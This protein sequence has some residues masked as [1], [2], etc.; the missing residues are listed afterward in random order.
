MLFKTDE[1]F[2]EMFEL[3]YEKLRSY[4]SNANVLLRD[5]SIYTKA[6]ST[7]LSGLDATKRLPCGDTERFQYFIQVFFLVRQLSLL[8]RNVPDAYL[9]LSNYCS[10]VK[11]NDALDLSNFV[12]F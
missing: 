6:S 4:Q 11:E 8:F 10:S 1:I 12:S 5:K 2:L 7:P 9:P 3:E